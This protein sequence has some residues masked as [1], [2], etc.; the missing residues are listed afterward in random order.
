MPEAM[1]FSLTDSFVFQLPFFLCRVSGD[2][3]VHKNIGDLFCLHNLIYYCCHFYESS[4]LKL[5]LFFP[6]AWFPMKNSH[7]DEETETR[8]DVT[9][10]WTLFLK[11]NGVKHFNFSI[12]LDFFLYVRQLVEAA[13]ASI[14]IFIFCQ[15]YEDIIYYFEQ[16]MVI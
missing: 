16:L 11:E 14:G 4:E 8:K 6:P 3:L 7:K 9:K 2:E 1:R 15:H 13:V 12:L 5:N 10:A